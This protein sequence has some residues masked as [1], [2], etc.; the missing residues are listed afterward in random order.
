MK[1][2][3]K[4]T[5]KRI[6]KKALAAK[7][8]RIAW[9]LL[10]VGIAGVIALIYNGRQYNLTI[11]NFKYIAL[12]HI[13]I[14][15]IS[16]L[17]LYN[18]RKKSD[19]KNFKVIWHFIFSTIFFGGIFCCMFYIT[20][21]LWADENIYIMSYEINERHYEYRRTPNSAD[22]AIDGIEKNIPF[23]NSTKAE[24]DGSNF[25]ELKLQ[26]GLWGFLVIVDKKLVLK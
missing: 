10:I 12:T 13:I 15:L 7:E 6:E 21:K 11:I 20:N 24:L 18:N 19:G 2:L 5:L 16:G 1:K 14:G 8:K 25:V 3:S 17:I 26:K 4:G 22:I 23:P 9:F